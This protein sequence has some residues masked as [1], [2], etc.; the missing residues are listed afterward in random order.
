MTRSGQFNKKDFYNNYKILSLVRNIE[1]AVDWKG[2]ADP[3]GNW[4]KHFVIQIPAYEATG[5]IRSEDE[6][7]HEDGVIIDCDPEIKSAVFYNKVE[8]FKGYN[9]EAVE[10]IPFKLNHRFGCGQFMDTQFMVSLVSDSHD[11]S[12]NKVM[13]IMNRNK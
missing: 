2:I 10:E 9:V 3:T 6:Y 11:L 4:T 1:G 7:P 5:W 8:Y 12:L 13:K